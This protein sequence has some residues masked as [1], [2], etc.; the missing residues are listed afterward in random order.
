MESHEHEVEMIVI[1]NANVKFKDGRLGSDSWW[2]R[3]VF[4]SRLL[5][6]NSG[7]RAA[8]CPK[9]TRGSV[10]KGKAAGA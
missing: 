3:K 6:D 2:G 9:D 8:S 7:A 1:R 5:L 4:S 10:L